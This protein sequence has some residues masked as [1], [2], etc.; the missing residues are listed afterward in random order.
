MG[1]YGRSVVGV[2]AQIGI[3]N[4]IYFP[5]D[6]GY[7][8]VITC[9]C[10]EFASYIIKSGAIIDLDCILEEGMHVCLDPQDRKSQLRRLL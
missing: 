8:D 6:N 3:G 5:N 7:I 1:S 4:D 10:A 9:A 2:A